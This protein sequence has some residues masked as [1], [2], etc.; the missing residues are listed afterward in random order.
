MKKLKKALLITVIVLVSF[1]GL[2][3]LTYAVLPKGPRE[4]MEFDD[5]FH[6]SREEVTSDNYMAAT[7]TPWATDAALEIMDE[8]GN[9]FDA[10]AA[11]L[12]TLNV[13]LPQA[14][15]FPGV[16]PLLI[17]DAANQ[18]VRS[19]IGAGT[20]PQKATIDYFRSKGH[21]TVPEMSIL[22]QL[23]PASPDVIIALLQDYGTMSFSTIA[24]PAIEVARVG[25]PI[26]E[27]MLHDL[28]FSVFERIGFSIIM[29]YNAAVYLKG[30][31]WRPLNHY[32]RFTFPD[33]A[34]T[35]EA[36]CLAEQAALDAGKTRNEALEAVRDYF[37][38]GE[39]ADRI[40]ALHEKK[41]GLFTKEDLAN[42]QGGW[43]EP[44]TG[45][46]NEYTFFANDTW[47]QGA[48][49]P[50]V[51]QILEGIDLLA[52]GHNT[53]AYMHTV[54]Q[55]I[56]LAMADKEA[57]FGDPEFVDV[58]IE[59]LLSKD[60]AASRRLL[61]TATAFGAIAPHGEPFDYQTFLGNKLVSGI[62]PSQYENK[63]KTISIGKDTSYISIIDADGN[64]VS[65]TPSDFPQS[66]MVDGLGL[67]LGIRMTQFRLNEAH[68]NRLEPGK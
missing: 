32:D 30:E 33:L 59:G 9:A 37:Y 3:G 24:A 14:A 34:D 38:K 68:P 26:H 63:T 55:A 35:F 17:Y 19:Y 5:P 64:A 21:K 12:L 15:S 46:Y 62:D 60:Y 2:F 41:G 39:I 47:S 52:M 23:L 61:M 13:T 29:P 40:V 54:L 6:V 67:T 50:M 44:L 25:F 48:V 18:E 45:S 66:P 16:A 1:I 58:P 11:A 4:I 49:L 53:P 31:W 27:M 43:E 28:N 10:T 20:A 65:L 42:Y 51:M 56:E 22:S 7:G 8:G 36:M 57:Y